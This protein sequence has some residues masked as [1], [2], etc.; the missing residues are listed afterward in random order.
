MQRSVSPDSVH[1]GFSTYT[2]TSQASQASYA[3]RIERRFVQAWKTITRSARKPERASFIPPGFILVN[4]KR[5][6]IMPV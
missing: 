4:A 2:T 1:S 3:R 6:S 5:R